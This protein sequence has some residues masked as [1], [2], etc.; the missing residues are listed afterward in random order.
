LLIFFFFFFI[1]SQYRA[2]GGARR[3]AGAATAL[4]VAGVADEDKSSASALIKCS[5]TWAAHRHPPC[6]RSYEHPSVMNFHHTEPVGLAVD[7]DE[8]S[9]STVRA[10]FP[11]PRASQIRRSLAQGSGR[12]GSR[13]HQ[14]AYTMAFGDAFF[15]RAQP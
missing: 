6:C 10:P 5:A 8:R 13:H 11:E 12:L 4:S 14:Q 15:L 7:E 9:K 2:R 1:F 3:R